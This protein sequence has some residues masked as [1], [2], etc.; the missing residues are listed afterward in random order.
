MRRR[1]WM[2]TRGVVEGA[3]ALPEQ[4]EDMKD[5]RRDCWNNEGK[6]VV[7]KSTEFVVEADTIVTLAFGR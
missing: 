2:V 5:G 1:D 7:T 4:S 6:P 3:E